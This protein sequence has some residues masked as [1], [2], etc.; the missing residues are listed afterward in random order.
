[1]SRSFGMRRWLIPLFAAVGILAIGYVGLWMWAE[2]ELAQGFT[3]WAATSQSSG[4]KVSSAPPERG[5]SPLAATLIIPDLSLSGGEDEV[6]G[7][8]TWHADRLVIELSLLHPRVVV[9]EAQGAQ[10]LRLSML[11]DVPYTADELEALLPVQ[12]GTP[13]NHLDIQAAKLNADMPMGRPGAVTVAHLHVHVQ[14]APD[15]VQT[16]PPLTIAMRAADVVLPETANWP[17]G[18][19]VA[20]ISGDATL[21]GQM[22]RIDGLAQR[23]AA[24]RDAGGQVKAQRVTIA[25]GS[26]NLSGSATIGLDQSLQPTGSGTAKVVDPSETLNALVSHGAITRRA[27]FAANAVL[28]LMEHVP[29]G[30]GSPV[31]EVPLTIQDRTVMVGSI[32]FAKLPMIA[33]SEL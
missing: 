21:N 22:P 31:V 5:K 9:I 28:A 16:E 19:R 12:V 7:G 18:P 15:G 26:L 3:T 1:M 17:L 24:W 23:A 11:P 30:G 20:V 8:L 13:P 27:A 2:H 14:W 6:P 10:R 33:W 4:W 25:W 32:P 29:E